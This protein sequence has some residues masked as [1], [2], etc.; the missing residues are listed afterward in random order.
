M[1]FSTSQGRRADGEDGLG[2]KGPVQLALK[3]VV[4]FAYIT[5]CLPSPPFRIAIN[6][7]VVRWV[8]AVGPRVGRAPPAL[9]PL[10]AHRRVAIATAASLLS[11][12]HMNQSFVRLFHCFG[13]LLLPCKFTTLIERHRPQVL[14]H[15][16]DD[17]SKYVAH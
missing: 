15:P 5:T 8:G 2:T 1:S 10:F 17:D 3:V 13:H 7:A 11:V 4:P 9:G 6:R 16:L 14:F 12:L